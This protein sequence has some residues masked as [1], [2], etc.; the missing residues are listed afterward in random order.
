MPNDYFTLSFQRTRIAPE[1]QYKVT[2]AFPLLK[3]KSHAVINYPE[4]QIF[5]NFVLILIPAYYHG[6]Q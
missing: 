6:F 3:V 5:C 2:T 4:K 1:A